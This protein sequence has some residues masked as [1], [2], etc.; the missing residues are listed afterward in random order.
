VARDAV[1]VEVVGL[2]QVA[3]LGNAYYNEEQQ[4]GRRKS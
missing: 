3:V 2:A 4:H 1:V